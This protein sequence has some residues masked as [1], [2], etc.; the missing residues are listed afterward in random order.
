VS[1][2]GVVTAAAV[3]LVWLGMVLAI[4][5]RQAPLKLPPPGTTLALGR[6]IPRPKFR[7]RSTAENALAALLAA[8]AVA[9]VPAIGWLLLAGPAGL[10]PAQVLMA[11]PWPARRVGAI[12]TGWTAAPSCQRLASPAVEGHTV[13]VL[14][15]VLASPVLGVVLA[16]S[17]QS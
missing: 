6:G 13:L 3:G 12:L 14:L 15:P 11:R 16:T 8:V 4:S 5:F 17:V 10:F 1:G 7:A 9:G 2:V